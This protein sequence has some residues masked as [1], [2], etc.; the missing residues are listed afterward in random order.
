[1]TG[2]N[3]RDLI[4]VGGNYTIAEAKGEKYVFLY[5]VYAPTNWGEENVID[6]DT[7]AGNY[8]NYALFV[9]YLGGIF[10]Y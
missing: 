1:M 9:T 3:D 2:L 6:A 10:K 8:I 4:G 5:R 7:E